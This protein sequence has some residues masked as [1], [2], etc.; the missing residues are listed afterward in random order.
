M[1]PDPCISTFSC[2]CLAAFVYRTVF[3]ADPYVSKTVGCES[4]W[5]STRDSNFCYK[6]SQVKM[7]WTDAN[8]Y[9]KSKGA[10]LVSIRSKYVHIL[11]AQE[12]SVK[13]AFLDIYGHYDCSHFEIFYLAWFHFSK[14]GS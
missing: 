14:V 2:G 7:N 13:V 9:C 5:K 1:D 10:N 6:L 8:A 3:I 12:N 11:I 4:R